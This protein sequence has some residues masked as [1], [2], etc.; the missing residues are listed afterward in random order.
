[1]KKTSG[2]PQII[3]YTIMHKDLGYGWEFPLVSPHLADWVF[4]GPGQDKQ[5]YHSGPGLAQ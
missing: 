3:I 5:N 1:M 2:I 4:G